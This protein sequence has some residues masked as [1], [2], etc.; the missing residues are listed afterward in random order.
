MYFIYYILYT[1][2]LSTNISILETCTVY[3]VHIRWYMY[4]HLYVERIRYPLPDFSFEHHERWTFQ[5]TIV[6]TSATLL[7]FQSRLLQFY[8]SRYR[9]YDHVAECGM[10]TNL[11]ADYLANK[12]R[13]S[14]HYT[15]L[16]KKH[17]QILVSPH[18]H[19]VYIMDS[20]HIVHS[21]MGDHSNRYTYL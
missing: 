19:H 18:I 8:F 15:W 16:Q 13:A 14:H 4:I 6:H 7:E 20:D 3:I 2:N 1:T 11:V 21:W 5:I 17:I 12:P 9:E 10:R